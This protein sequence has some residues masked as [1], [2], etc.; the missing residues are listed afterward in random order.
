MRIAPVI[1]AL[2][3]AHSAVQAVEIDKNQIE[4]LV[5]RLQSDSFRAL[6]KRGTEFSPK[7]LYP[8][9]SWSTQSGLFPS[10]VHLNF[11][12]QPIMARGRNLY[13]F[14]DSNGF[15]SM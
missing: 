11:H 9:L 14:P 10:F 2:S 6:W 3:A 4:T 7:F 13:N 5:N 12:G 8:P 1:L 15:V